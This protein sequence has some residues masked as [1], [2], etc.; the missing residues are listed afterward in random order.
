MTK[1]IRILH[2]YDA[3]LNIY[4]D[5]GNILVL[6]QRCAWRDLGCEVVGLA[7]GETFDPAD[8]DLIYVG[9]GQDRDQAM[10]AERMCADLAEPIAAAVDDGT[11]L[12]AVCGG[13]Q[14]LGRRYV[15]TTGAEL[16]GTG[17]FD[18]ETI[19]GDTRCIGNAS[20][21]AALPSLGTEPEQT[22]V[23][24]GFENHA[25]RT[26]L[27]QAAT[28]WARVIAGYGNDGTGSTEGCVRNRAIG[29]YLHGPLLPRNPELADWL[30]RA[31]LASRY[32]DG[33]TAIEPLIDQPFTIRARDVARERALAEKR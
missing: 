23:V 29:T 11:A 30:I 10:I 19:A 16:P 13:Y 4:A 24:H 6:Q 18:L 9:G 32:G 15:D 28:P 21:E 14:L 17:L 33:D 20:V 8:V 1:S 22:T 12:L 27:D 25:G 31:A 3:F 26:Q 7:P 5:R 2:L